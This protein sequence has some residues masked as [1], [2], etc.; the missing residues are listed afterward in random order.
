MTEMI[1]NYTYFAMVLVQLVHYML[2]VKHDTLE[3]CDTYCWF[4]C[5]AVNTN[6]LATSQ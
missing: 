1:S 2:C 3:Q 5:S 4:S 6:I